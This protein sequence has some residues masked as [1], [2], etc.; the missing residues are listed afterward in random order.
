MARFEAVFFDSGGTLFEN[1]GARETNGWPR[2]GERLA[3]ALR[4]WDCQ[5]DP[6]ELDRART[7]LE[8]D[9]PDRSGPTFTHYQLVQAVASRLKLGLSPEELAC[10][11]DMYSGPRF[12]SWLFPGTHDM[13]TQLTE[14]GLYLGLIANTHW[15]GWTMERA[16]TGVGLLGYFRVRVYSGDLGIE[17]PDVGIFR[18]AER[19]ANLSA[20]PHLLYVGDSME[21]DVAGALA[22]NWSVALRTSA[23]S[24]GSQG[25]AALDFSRWDQLLNFILS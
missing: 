15:P 24:V 4:A 1:S 16:F 5:F 25:R 3:A 21:K 19:C 7:E 2:R 17:K 23:D 22:A 8:R 11:T 12:R 6:E 14:A 9:L 10:V 18:E 13:L 20:G